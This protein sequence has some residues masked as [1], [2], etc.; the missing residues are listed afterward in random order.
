MA[1]GFESC[2]INII[3][4]SASSRRE[5]DDTLWEVKY[6]I[7]SIP[8]YDINQ[9]HI[10]SIENFVD[11]RSYS[12]SQAN[13]CPFRNELIINVEFKKDKKEIKQCFFY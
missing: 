12:A 1:N 11:V 13:Y 3:V 8:I 4:K 5:K 9:S 10:A 2:T 7:V 6:S